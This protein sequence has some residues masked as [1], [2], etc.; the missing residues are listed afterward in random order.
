MSNSSA[1]TN[2]VSNA[3]TIYETIR[4]EILTLVLAP[5]ST[6][7]ENSMA[8]RFNVSRSPVREAF[9]RLAADGLIKT[10]PN[11]NSQVSP[12]AL[13]DFPKFM[14]A[15]DLVQRAVTR[16]AAENHTDIDL[17]IIKDKNQQFKEA[18]RSHDVVAMIDSNHAF[19]MAIS[20]AS[21]NSYFTL[22][23]KRLL[24]EGKRTLRI[25]Y[26]LFDDNPPPEMVDNHDLIIEAIENKNCNLADKLAQQHANQLSDGFITYLSKRQSQNMHLS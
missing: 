24:D 7:D 18:V 17:Q 22:M 16:L 11:K 25:Y 19:H 20:E 9:I 2:K 8:K 10:L 14:D 12:L 23:Y 4:E 3:V 26:R 6:I 21:K 15:L 5:S 13:E 1:P